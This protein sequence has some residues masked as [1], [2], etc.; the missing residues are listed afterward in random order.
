MTAETG[1]DT[2]KLGA[3][4]VC[5]GVT[6]WSRHMLQDECI[7]TLRLRVEQM[8]EDTADLKRRVDELALT[9]RGK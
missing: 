8:R 4:R 6:P 3:C 5:G 1:E 9:K 7:A 2:E